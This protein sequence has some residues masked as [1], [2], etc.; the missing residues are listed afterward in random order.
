MAIAAFV[1]LGVAPLHAGEL[2]PIGRWRTFDRATGAQ[3]G[4]IE[5]TDKDG[6]LE[7]RV[8]KMIAMPGDP[9]NPVCHKCAR[10]D[11]DQPVLGMTVLKGLKHEGNA[12]VDGTILDPHTGYVYGS[13]IRLDE[14]GTKLFVRGYLGISLMGRT[15]TWIRE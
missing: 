9:A 2:S 4:V 5:I 15:V 12:W 1:F 8:V 7:G 3:N 6:T 13:E 11:K 14:S 10:P